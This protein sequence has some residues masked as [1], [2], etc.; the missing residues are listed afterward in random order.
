MAKWETIAGIGTTEA[1]ARL[2]T[3]SFQRL[4]GR[5]LVEVN[6]GESVRDKLYDAPIVVLSHGTEDDPVLNYG[7]A[8][9]QAL[10]EREWADFTSIPSRLTAEPMERAERDQ[11]LKKVAEQGYDDDFNGIRISSSG[12]RIAIERGIVWNLI[13]EQGVYRGQAAAFAT[14]GYIE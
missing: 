8:A 12:R 7:N 5:A 14:Y 10:W 4:L 13:D 11:F 1:H 2:I 3:G 6:E 9:A